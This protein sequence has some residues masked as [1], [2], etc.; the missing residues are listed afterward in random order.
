MP[1][2]RQEETGATGNLTFDRETRTKI[3]NTTY[4]AWVLD[5]F[6]DDGT[7]VVSNNDSYGSV[8]R[9]TMQEFFPE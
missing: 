5:S 4:M 1:V 9:E 2:N 8:Y 7:Q 6:Y 3:L